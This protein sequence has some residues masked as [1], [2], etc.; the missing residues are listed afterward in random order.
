MTEPS[1]VG[2]GVYAPRYRIDTETIGE[3]LGRVQAAG[4]AEKRVPAADED[5]LTMGTAAAHRALVATGI[6]AADVG[7]LVVAST[8]PP[9][10]EE[11]LTPRLA[12]VLGVENAVHRSLGGSTRT[13][14]QALLVA[15]DTAAYPALVVAADC[16][17][18]EPT[19][20]EEHAAGAGAVA[21][22]VDADPAG[23]GATLTARAEYVAAYP[24]TRFREQGEERVSGLGISSYDRQ[25]YREC[26]SGAVDRLDGDAVATADA[27]ALQA[28]DGKLPG[29][30]AGALET[31]ADLFTVAGDRG[32]LGA[33]SAPAALARAFAGGAGSVL[34]VG[35]GS[36]AA[37]DALLFEGT[38]PVVS[39]GSW[40]P[41]SIDYSKYLRLR[42]E[43]DS[44]PPAGGGAQ[45]S[46]PSWRRQRGARYRLDAGQCPNCGALAF[47]AEGACPECH[48]LVSYEP[49]R[50]SHRGTVETVTGVSPGGAPPEFAPQAERGGEFGVSIVSFPPADSA[51]VETE[52][53]AS[54]PMQVTDTDP[55]SVEPGD[56]VVAVIRR[57]YTQEGVT[58]YG[59]KIRPVE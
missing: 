59:R 27:L 56:A 51:S 22:V 15:A 4:I 58:R 10:A 34:T 30:A 44:G 17:R 55:T 14:T 42:G 31:D 5:A 48:D 43:L 29:R 18:G 19:S 24:G 11:E 47:P 28:P 39:T 33:A 57:I 46:V 54:V 12:A 16:P 45:V 1:I 7:S 26:V 25:A 13:G 50:L 38:A 23:T 2:A 40:E 49:A 37:A 20:P 8:T 3:A 6:A 41:A 52:E 35:F 21:F 53:T 9:L 32:D 36:G